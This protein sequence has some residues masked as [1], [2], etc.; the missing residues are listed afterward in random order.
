M[1][2]L[3]FS[4]LPTTVLSA[5]P[6]MPVCTYTIR[7][8]EIDG[9]VLRYARV[10]EQVVHRWECQSDSY[11][12]LVHSCFVEDGQGQRMDVVDARGCHVDEYIFNDPTYIEALTMAYREA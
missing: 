10:G 4:Q 8:D 3:L 7:K 6:Q 12:M 2:M 9:A 5:A 1:P 11:G